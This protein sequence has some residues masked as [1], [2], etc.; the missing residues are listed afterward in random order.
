[1][2]NSDILIAVASKDGRLINQHFGHAERFLIY[3]AR[4]G[5][6]EFLEE[7]KVNKYCQ[8]DD[9]YD[10]PYE[11]DRFMSV[12]NTI[13]D[14]RFVLTSMIGT[15]PEKKLKEIDIIPVICA[16][17]IEEGIEKIINHEIKY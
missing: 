3:K 10:H 4:A 14:C 6:T 7:R 13:K 16:D 1:M 11:D 8:E 5:K 12:A 15:I 2:N 9:E 17:G